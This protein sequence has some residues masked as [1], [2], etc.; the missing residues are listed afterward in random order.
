MISRWLCAV[1]ALESLLAWLLVR[2]LAPG[3]PLL[4]TLAAALGLAVLAS[5]GLLAASYALARRGAAPWL[6]EADASA[7][8]SG[9][10]RAA[11]AEILALFAL[12]VLIQP[13]ERLWM[14][15]DD[16]GR[17][18]RGRCPVLLVHGYLCNRG[19]WW[20]LRQRLRARGAVV[21]TVNLEPPLADLEALV[22]TLARRID[23]LLLDTGAERVALVAHSM[24]GLVC[25]AY[26]RRHGCARVARLLTVA[27][28]HHGT[29]MARRA[30]GVNAGQMRVGSPWLQSLDA[31]PPPAAALASLWSRRDEVVVPPESSQLSF[32]EDLVFEDLGHMALLFSPRVAARI[33]RFLSESCDAVP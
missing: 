14:G 17:T 30:P 13:F 3:A 32:A 12:F 28:P 16:P 33:E 9:A 24:G 15:R 31:S 26:L 5:L 22:E 8:A 18:A 7:S 1:L 2:A 11:L 25:R 10:R 29:R 4:A 23:R 21:A 19:I 6:Q 20:R 27:A